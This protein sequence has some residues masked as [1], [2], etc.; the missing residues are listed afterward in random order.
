MKRVS[1]RDGH[2]D[3]QFANIIVDLCF[4]TSYKIKDLIAMPRPRL[5]LLIERFMKHYGK[6]KVGRR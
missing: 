6:K 3:D 5:D 2:A 4:F 1:G